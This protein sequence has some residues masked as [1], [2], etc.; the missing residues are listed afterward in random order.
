MDSEDIDDKQ[1]VRIHSEDY[2]APFK[3]PILRG[4]SSPITPRR[5]GVYTPKT[6]PESEGRIIGD[7]ANCREVDG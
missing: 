2:I 5:V 7:L 4:A 6:K 3:I 1:T